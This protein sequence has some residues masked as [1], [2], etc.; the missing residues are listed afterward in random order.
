MVDLLAISDQE[1]STRS[2]LE[3][4]AAFLTLSHLFCHLRL[5]RYIL[6][7][8]KARLTVMV[9]QLAW[10]VSKDPFVRTHS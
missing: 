7:T 4:V 10:E 9:N 3:H 8:S 1:E 6:D 5:V 2:S